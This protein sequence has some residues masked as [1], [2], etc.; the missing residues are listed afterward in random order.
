M[1]DYDPQAP[2]PTAASGATSGAHAEESMDSRS[3]GAIVGDIAQ[4]LTALIRQEIELAKTELKQELTKMGKGV[5]MLGG[6]GVAGHLTLLFLSLFLM[7]VLA[8]W[9]ADY[10][11]A[12]LVV[13]LLWAIIAG[14]LAMIGRKAL[15]ES[16]P[17]LPT[18]QQSLK[19]D[20]QWAKAQKN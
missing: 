13:T 11:W 19:E 5:G 6:A 20:V 2:G 7:F 14:V 10:K 18:T 8:D 3:L 9:F 1:T 12:A 15:K 16:R 4:D 17:E